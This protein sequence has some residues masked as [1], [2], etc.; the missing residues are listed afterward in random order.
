MNVHKID[1]RAHGLASSSTAAAE[2]SSALSTSSVPSSLLS[3]VL[4]VSSEDDGISPSSGSD[5]EFYAN[6]RNAISSQ[7]FDHELQ[8]VQY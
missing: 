7:F 2:T 8:L 5:A 1:T 3:T 6:W 4:S